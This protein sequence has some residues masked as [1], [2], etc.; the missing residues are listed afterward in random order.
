MSN[1]STPR[2]AS[3]SSLE[4][5]QRFEVVAESRNDEL[6]NV[7]N[8][9]QTDKI[10]TLPIKLSL[11]CTGCNFYKTGLIDS[12]AISVS[13]PVTAVSSIPVEVYTFKEATTSFVRDWSLAFFGI[14]GG[15]YMSIKQNLKRYDKYAPSKLI[16]IYRGIEF[17]YSN[18]KLL[19]NPLSFNAIIEPISIQ[20][21]Q[22]ILKNSLKLGIGIHFSAQVVSYLVK[23]LL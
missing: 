22:F 17:D 21:Q 20:L 13:N 15:V 19:K 23:V 16:N 4:S 18:L 3:N 6:V 12:T 7:N 1:S 2:S 14:Q 8:L 5:T 10:F 11:L 9:P